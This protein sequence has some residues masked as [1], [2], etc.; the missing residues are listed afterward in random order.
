MGIWNSFK[1]QLGRDAGKVGSN[2]LWKDKHAPV[3]RRAE[4]RKQ[5]SLDFKRLL[6]EAEQ[7]RLKQ[8]MLVQLAYKVEDKIQQSSVFTIS[9]DKNELINT[10]SRLAILLK[11]NPIKDS[12]KTKN[13]INNAYADAILAK[14]E[15][16]F[17][18]FVTNYSKNGTISHYANILKSAKQLRFFKR[19]MSICIIACLFVSF[20]IIIAIQEILS[21]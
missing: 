13:K 21:S 1:G 3:Y 9:N 20:V 10:L 6:F 18:A 15:Q 7:K 5:E 12:I 19:Y 4:S 17:I 11:T 2:F 14:Y 8:D 16:V